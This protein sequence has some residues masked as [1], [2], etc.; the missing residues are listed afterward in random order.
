MSLLL[1]RPEKRFKRSQSG[2]LKAHLLLFAFERFC[3]LGLC[4]LLCS[5]SRSSSSTFTQPTPAMNLLVLLALVLFTVGVQGSD[6]V[7]CKGP[8]GQDVEWW[9]LYQYDL[10]QPF[11]YADSSNPA[12]F[13]VPAKDVALSS[14]P[15]FRTVEQLFTAPEKPSYLALSRRQV[16]SFFPVESDGDELDYNTADG[17]P[18]DTTSSNP[19]ILLGAVNRK[20]GGSFVENSF[21]IFHSDPTFPPLRSDKLGI[22]RPSTSPKW[23]F[24]AQPS[25]TQSLFYFCSSFSLSPLLSP[26]SSSSL[27]LLPLVTFL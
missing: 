10:I 9:I 22:D 26:S 21:G 18:I 11:S 7:S 17:F 13:D 3:C 5:L 25:E 8:S 2:Q 1:A 19:D 14:S 4:P 24:V 12:V 23:P 27:C 20:S 6:T 16:S 15:L